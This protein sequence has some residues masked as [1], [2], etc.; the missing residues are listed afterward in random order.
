MDLNTFGTDIIKH[1]SRLANSAEAIEMSLKGNKGPASTNTAGATVTETAAEKKTRLAAE[2]K[3]ADAAAAAAAPKVERAAVNA[4]LV[5]VKD[6][7][8]KEAAQE[9][10]KPF[11]YAAMSKIEEKDFANVLAAAEKELEDFANKT[12][13]YE[14]GNAPLDAEDDL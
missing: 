6:T 7:I 2:K 4:A 14:E 8:S 13:K 10:Y 9:L 5:A 11:G 3:A 1:L 12:G